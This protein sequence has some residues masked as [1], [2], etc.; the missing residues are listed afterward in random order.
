[1]NEKLSA[2][3]R[4]LAIELGFPVLSVYSP[5]KPGQPPGEGEVIAIF[6]AKDEDTMM[7][8]AIDLTTR[9]ES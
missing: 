2:A 9:Q 1:M 4:T 6:F 8:A 3:I 7:A 5:S